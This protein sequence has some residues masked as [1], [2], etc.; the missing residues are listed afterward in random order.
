[1]LLARNTLQGQSF[2]QRRQGT[3][4]VNSSVF[5]CGDSRSCRQ[6]LHNWSSVPVFGLWIPPRDELTAVRSCRLP[7]L[8]TTHLLR[9]QGQDT[10]M[11]RAP[12]LLSELVWQMKPA[13]PA[14]EPAVGLEWKCIVR[15]W[16]RHHA[17]FVARQKIRR[18]PRS[19]KLPSQQQ[20]L[21]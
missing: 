21:A 20:M 9:R 14:A 11:K 16:F 13:P 4:R 15:A 6:K 10:F 1:M 2:F 17:L 8:Q 18:V 19:Q 7:E 3:H 5:G 12:T